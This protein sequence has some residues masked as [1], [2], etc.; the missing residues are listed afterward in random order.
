MFSF[1]IILRADVSRAAPLQRESTGEPIQT[2]RINRC[3]RPAR[4]IDYRP[5]AV[6]CDSDFTSASRLKGTRWMRREGPDYL[7]DSTRSEKL[8]PTLVSG[9]ASVSVDQNDD[10]FT[11][12]MSGS[13]RNDTRYR[14]QRLKARDDPRQ[15]TTGLSFVIKR[16][17][18]DQIELQP[19]PRT[20]GVFIAG[21]PDPNP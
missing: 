14:G 8:D 4:Q 1:R 2:L 5:I 7:Q 15:I 6:H 18:A 21:N 17:F 10:T 20:P 3:N 16:P 12:Q 19:F 13:D 9:G 11:I